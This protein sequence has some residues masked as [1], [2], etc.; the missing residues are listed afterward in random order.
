MAYM[1][2]LTGRQRHSQSSA[3]ISAGSTFVGESHW[4]ITH[5]LLDL[6]GGV[7]AQWDS[8]SFQWE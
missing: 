6:L 7:R 1:T 8:L 3:A 2:A 4:R 5:A